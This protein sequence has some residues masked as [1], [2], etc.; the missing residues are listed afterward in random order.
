[1]TSIDIITLLDTFNIFA[2]IKDTIYI[3]AIPSCSNEGV[4]FVC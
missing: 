1:M 3:V 2:E 4:N